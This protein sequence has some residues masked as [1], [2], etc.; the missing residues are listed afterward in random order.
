MDGSARDGKEKSLSAIVYRLQTE[1]SQLDLLRVE[2]RA[3]FNPGGVCERILESV[4]CDSPIQKM[5]QHSYVA[6]CFAAYCLPEDLAGR[7]L[8]GAWRIGAPVASAYSALT[9]SRWVRD[10]Y[11][12][13]PDFS[14]PG[15]PVGVVLTVAAAYTLAVMPVRLAAGVR[16]QSYAGWAHRE[17]MRLLNLN[18]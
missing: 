14:H 6:R 4:E 7:V 16:M 10:G 8:V 13:L 2:Y 17:K 5:Y 9:F 1:S 15:W 3:V 11:M 12:V 18:E